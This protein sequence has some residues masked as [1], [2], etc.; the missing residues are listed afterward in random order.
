MV[1]LCSV[2]GVA[3]CALVAEL[4]SSDD[5]ALAV[6]EPHVLTLPTAKQLAPA[7]ATGVARARGSG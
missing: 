2:G 4:V 7:L 5:L 6:A 3:V 1:Y